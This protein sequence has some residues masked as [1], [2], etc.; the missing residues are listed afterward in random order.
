MFKK[1]FAVVYDDII[2]LGS[3]YDSEAEKFTSV[4]T[5]ARTELICNLLNELNDKCEFL[6]A[7]NESIEKENENL[8]AQLCCDE[9]V[10]SICQY[11][12]LIEHNT[13]YYVAKCEKGHEKCSK[14]D[15]N[16][17]EDFKCKE[18]KE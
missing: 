14:D 3:I 8:K 2:D 1:R 11:Q 9:S 15:I 5:L 10:C 18:L 4:G 16:Y 13:G 7:K 17:C 12:H 6:E